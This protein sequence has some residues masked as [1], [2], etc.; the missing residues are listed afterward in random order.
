MQGFGS[1][2]L[3]RSLRRNRTN[4]LVGRYVETNSLRI[5]LYVATDRSD[6]S[7]GSVGRYV[8]T[9]SLRI[10]RYVATDQTA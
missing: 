2:P 1:Y 10:G 7:R 3:D 6:R 5:G 4:G 8:A 9:D